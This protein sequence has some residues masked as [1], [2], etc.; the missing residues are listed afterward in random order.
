MEQ[1][2]RD[3]LA[4]ADIKNFRFHDC[5]HTA[6]SYMAQHGASLLEIADT[7]GH[8]QLRMVQ[9]YAHLNTDSRRRLMARVFE[10]KL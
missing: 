5:R 3:A 10:G 4:L 9:R 2:F 7:L 8:R 1:A 6:A